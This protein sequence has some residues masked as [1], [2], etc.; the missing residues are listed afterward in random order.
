M[1]NSKAWN[2]NLVANDDKYWNSP[3][4]EIY[5][6]S[7]NWKEKNFTE[8][9][10][11]GCGFGRNCIFMAK[12]NFKVSTFDLSKKSVEI[13]KKNAKIQGIKFNDIRVADMLNIPYPDNSFDCILAMNVI[14]HTDKNGFDKI[15]S[16]IKRVLKVNGEVYFTVGS[17]ESF[18]FKNTD[19]L[20]VDEF[21]KIR[22]E[23][24]PENGIPHFFIND[25]DCKTL[26][27][28]FKI[29]QILNIRD[30]TQVGKFSPH[31]HIWL[32]KT[33]DI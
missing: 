9:L 25:N 8:F 14:S 30:L 10:D 6:L 13:T 24:G 2:W 27:N 33:D 22:V 23:N 11:I 26:F 32:K 18:W 12:H 29:I 28:D 21:T 3:S 5:F 1:V 19:C 31:Y 17:K 7:E 15:L 20:Y 4:P 16:E